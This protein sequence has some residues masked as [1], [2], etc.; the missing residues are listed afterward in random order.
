MTVE[1]LKDWIG[2]LPKKDREEV[3]EW[4][5]AIDKLFVKVPGQHLM[6]YGRTGTGKT[7]T[8]YYIHD[9]ISNGGK[10][11]TIWFDSGKS[12]E[13][14]TLLL[15]K[16]LKIL[17]PKSKNLNIEIELFR[18]HKELLSKFNYNPDIIEE[19]LSKSKLIPIIDPL[20][21]TWIECDPNYVNVISY[22]KFIIDP[23]MVSTIYS[24][25]FMDL[26]ECA[27]DRRL[28]TPC[29]ILMDEMQAICPSRKNALD[30]RHIYA[31]SVLISNLQQCRSLGLRFVGAAPGYEEIRPAARLT[32]D[33]MVAKRG[34]QF[35]NE[36]RRL[37][38]FN[39][40]FERC[41][42]DAGY[43]IF[44]DRNYSHK[45]HFPYYPDGSK[46]GRINYIGHIRSKRQII[47]LDDLE[48]EEEEAGLEQI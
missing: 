19:N 17:I 38:K 16:P 10:E 39:P 32:F 46:I 34:A 41:E 35:T 33:W 12:G 6:V 8:L 5:E 4:E 1:A 25:L 3:M 13:I 42:T 24:G 30:T 20:K 18:E 31:S 23:V 14:L 26:I 15:F 7:Q 48:M 22:R 43:W 9:L 36:Q 45:L 29:T 2:T 37:Y 40:R 44:P 27:Y 11:Y 21:R 28:K 47:N